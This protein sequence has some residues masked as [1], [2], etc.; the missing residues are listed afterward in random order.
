MEVTSISS[1]GSHRPPFEHPPKSPSLAQ[2]SAATNPSQ[3]TDYM[4]KWDISV[5]QC[6]TYTCL[7]QHHS[8]LY[9]RPTFRR[10]GYP[11][12]GL[13]TYWLLLNKSIIQSLRPFPVGPYL[14]R[15][16]LWKLNMPSK[17]KFFGWCLLQGRFNT[18]TQLKT[19]PIIQSNCICCRQENETIDKLFHHCPSPSLWKKFPTHISNPIAY[20]TMGIWC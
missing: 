20:P 2:Q 18:S 8:E 5:G 6:Q 13:W 15:T 4:S 14:P 19:Y 12:L 1:Y 10:L 7:G 16:R 11:L 3:R 17:L 9:H